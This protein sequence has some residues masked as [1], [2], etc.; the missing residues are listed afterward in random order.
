MTRTLL[1]YIGC[2]AGAAA[3]TAG[4][5]LVAGLGVALIVAGVLTVAGAATL[6]DI[7]GGSE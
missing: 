1:A 2:G 4:V 6:V 5:L 3:V 7:D